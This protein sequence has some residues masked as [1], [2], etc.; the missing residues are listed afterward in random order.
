MNWIYILVLCL[1]IYYIVARYLEKHIDNFDPSL[2]PVSSIVT[3]AKVA[4]KLVDGGGTLTNPGNLQIGTAAAPGNLKVTGTT[5][6]DGTLGVQAATTTPGKIATIGNINLTQNVTSLANATQSEISNDVSTS[7]GGL[8]ILG[9]SSK[10]QDPADA[11]NVRNTI[12]YDAVT[13][14]SYNI[15]KNTLTVNGNT[16]VTGNLTVNG[17]TTMGNGTWHLSG[18]KIKR[19]YFLNGA[20]TYFGSNS[21]WHFQNQVGSLNVVTIDQTGNTVIQGTAAFKFKE[22]N[23]YVRPNGKLALWFGSE[24]GGYPDNINY[25]N[26]GW[27]FQNNKTS[28]VVAN[29]DDKGNATFN[30]NILN[31]ASAFRIKFYMWGIAYLTQKDGVPTCSPTINTT[32]NSDYWMLCGARLLNLQTGTFFTWDGASTTKNFTLENI[33]ST[34]YQMVKYNNNRNDGSNQTVYRFVFMP[35]DSDTFGS[36]AGGGKYTPGDSWYIGQNGTLSNN[37]TG[38][39]LYDYGYGNSYFIMVA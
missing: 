5:T 13:I 37:A 22:D 20:D 6:L 19:L 15:P 17:T 27:W 2:V 9:N 39:Q 30:G 26:R 8:T 33:N 32:D 21:S 12:F 35:L 23:H 14:N 7:Y 24:A 18:D 29:I 36:G 3:L 11:A 28:A 38:I 1:A 4:Q 34:K 10:K 16:T 25:S 31:K